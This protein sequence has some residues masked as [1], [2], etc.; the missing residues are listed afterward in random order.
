MKRTPV[1][2]P[3]KKSSYKKS[4]HKT[5]RKRCPKRKKKSKTKRT[6]KSCK[7]G[8]KRNPATNRCRKIRMKRGQMPKKKTSPLTQS[9]QRLALSKFS[10][11]PTDLI[12]KIGLHIHSSVYYAKF[13]DIS[14]EVDPEY[15]EYR[16]LRKDEGDIQRAIDEHSDFNL[17]DI[18]FVGSTYESRQEYGFVMYVP[19]YDNFGK[20]NYVTTELISELPLEMKKGN[21]YGVSKTA[22][23]DV[24]YSKMV[25]DFQ[26]NLESEDEW[27]RELAEMFLATDWRDDDEIMEE[28]EELDLW[29]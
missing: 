29:D 25:N 14:K 18:L 19:G 24:R 26:N 10:N 1:K 4:P 3:K 13:Y 7:P 5:R 16:Y 9:Q 22:L 23:D 28:Y 27:D 15:H 11:I 12:E 8:Q 21:V 20:K 17:G 6:L 2:L